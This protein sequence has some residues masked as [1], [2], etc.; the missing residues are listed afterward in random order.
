MLDELGTDDA[1]NLRGQAA[2]AN[3]RLAWAAYQEI[4]SS[5]RWKALAEQGAHPQRPLWASTGVKD[6]AYDD[7]RYVVELVAPGCVNTMPEGTLK[8]V[9][10]HGVSRGDT[11][12]HTQAAS[13]AVWEKLAALGIEPSN[14]F[15]TLEQEGVDK[16][17]AAWNQ[18]RDALAKVLA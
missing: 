17:I 15:A 12:S 16:F 8:A 4:L 7:T 13:A 2:I 9:A 14:V 3:A 1:H 5:S 18:L 10:D 6:K 11:V